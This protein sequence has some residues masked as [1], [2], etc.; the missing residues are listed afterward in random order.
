MV[1]VFRHGRHASVDGGGQHV[2]VDAGAKPPPRPG[3][4]DG[5]H[6]R[7]ALG[8]AGQVDHPRDH[9]TGQRV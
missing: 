1:G 7:I 3:D 6:L 8:P 2:A 9:G 4:A 5:D